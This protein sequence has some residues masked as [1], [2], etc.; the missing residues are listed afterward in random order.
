MGNAR[1]ISKDKEIEMRVYK[2][3]DYMLENKST[4]RKTAEAFGVSKTTVHK[5]M[6]IRLKS[7]N[8]FLYKEIRK[9]LNRNF[10]VKHIRGGQ[11]VRKRALEKRGI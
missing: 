7:I 3:A 9:L 5:D 1:T 6:T 10:D 4:I 11:E 8:L 2:E